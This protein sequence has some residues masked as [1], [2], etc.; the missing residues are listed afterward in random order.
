M[1]ACAQS[2]CMVLLWSSLRKRHSRHGLLPLLLW[3]LLL[4]RLQ[5]W[6]RL[7]LWLLLLLLL[8][9]LLQWLLHHRS[10]RLLMHVMQL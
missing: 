8:P 5:M 2:T 3:L 1:T 6:L 7:P 10:W 9:A 4:W